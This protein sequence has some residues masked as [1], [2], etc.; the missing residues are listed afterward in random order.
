M[1]E[2]ARTERRSRKAFASALSRLEE[3]LDAA[4]AG[5]GDWPQNV[6]A[7]VRAGLEFAA[8]DPEAARLLI[9][10]AAEDPEGAGVHRQLIE[11]LTARL[12]DAAHER[13]LP[14]AQGEV[15]V[16][17]VLAMVAIRLTL[18]QAQ[19]LPTAG[20]EAAEFLFAPYLGDEAARRRI[21]AAIDVSISN[22]G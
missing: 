8:T 9:I 5:G 17:G 12:C 6:I 21:A 16:S 14:D 3:A 1:S 13:G 18:G 22:G 11:S 7:A 4:C 15:L 20:L 2:E 10:E 19:T